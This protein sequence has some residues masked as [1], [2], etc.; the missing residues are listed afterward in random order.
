MNATFYKK[1]ANNVQIVFR[2]TDSEVSYVGIMVGSG[3]RDEGETEG[4]LAHYIEHCVFKGTP[5]RSARDIIDHIE[6]VG[7]E[8]NAYTT[9]EETTFY[10]ATPTRQWRK[11]LALL[12]DMVLHPTFPKK[13]TDKEVGVILDEIDSYEDSPSELIYDD[14]EGLIFDQHSLSRPILGTKKTVK[15]IAKH[16]AVAQQF[17][18]RQYRPERTVVFVQGNHK[19][20]AIVAAVEQLLGGDWH[21]NAPTASPRI[22]PANYTPQ[23]RSYKK[24]THQVHVML[25]SRAYPI[26]HPKNLV[27]YLL[28][29]ILGGGSMSSRLNLTLR[30]KQGLVY[31]IESQ[32]T[33]L[34]DTG[35]WSIYFAADAKDKDKCI[36]L[37][38]HELQILRD[39]PLSERQLKRALV[40]L[41]GQMAISAENQENNALAMAKL[42][43]YHGVAPTWEE[44]YQRIAQ[45]TANDL[46]E[47]AQE[48]FNERLISTLIYE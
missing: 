21:T 25:G 46:Q 11:T 10:A 8:I 19:S 27:L 34:S 3:T 26:G 44:T 38:M 18:Q 20:D 47:V 32:Y 36:G 28:N 2:K 22:A 45:I 24:H 23:Q 13:E 31:T 41:R 12:A 15:Q 29:N 33:P 6:G 35:Y 1:I 9:K 7:G 16:S 37:I 4:G 39:K 40:Q 48:I 43:L 30:E 17:M 5:T 14:F 42:M